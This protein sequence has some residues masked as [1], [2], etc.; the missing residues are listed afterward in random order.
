[1]KNNENNELIVLSEVIYPISLDEIK[2]FISEW[3][4]VPTLDP[5]NKDK[6]SYIAV[7]KAH[8][9]AV[10]FRTSIE[11]KRK[12]LKAPAIAYGK[13]VDSIAKEFQELINPKELELF[14][15]R[16][17]VLLSFKVTFI[18]SSFKSNCDAA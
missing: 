2:D 7:K 11:K 16:N 3:K 10:R 8:I 14:A 13:N 1:M 9:E 18:L 4:E 17:K 15:S 6:E 5:L 12:E